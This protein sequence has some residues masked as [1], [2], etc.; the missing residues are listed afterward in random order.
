M[1]KDYVRSECFEYL[2]RTFKDNYF[3]FNETAQMP[4]MFPRGNVSSFAVPSFSCLGSF[5]AMCRP[6]QLACTLFSIF[7]IGLKLIE[8]TG[9]RKK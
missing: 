7:R 6:H 1:Q 3:F 8:I 2:E 5:F 9:G 4:V